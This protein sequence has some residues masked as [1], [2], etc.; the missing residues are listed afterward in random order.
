MRLITW[1]K[2][3][4]FD[5]F[6]D[7]SD[8]EKGDALIGYK[9][10]I[11]QTVPRTV[12]TKLDE[13]VSVKD[14]GAKGN[15]YTD[16]SLAIQTAIDHTFQNGTGGSIFF[17]PGN[18][19]VKTGIHIKGLRITL[20]G[21]GRY[22]T[23]VTFKPESDNLTLFK[24][25]RGADGLSWQC[26]IQD[27]ALVSSGST[28]FTKTALELKDTSNMI[29]KDLIIGPWTGNGNSIGLLIRGRE[30][31]HINN[32]RIQADRPIFIGKNGSNPNNDLDHFHF[33][34]LYLLVSRG[35]SQPC[36]FIDNGVDM[37]HVIFD[38]FQAWVLGTHGLY[39]HDTL[40][41]R[42]ALALTFRNIRTEQSTYPNGYSIYIHRNQPIQDLIIENMVADNSQRGFF[43][44][45]INRLTMRHVVHNGSSVALDIDEV[46][47]LSLEQVL[48]GRNSN[49][50]MPNMQEKFALNRLESG[51]P[52][53]DTAYFI[54][55]VGLASSQALHFFGGTKVWSFSGTLPHN[56]LLTIPAGNNQGRKAGVIWVSAITEDETINAGGQVMDTINGAIRLA[57][58][59]NFDVGNI[60]GKLTVFHTGATQIFNKLGQSVDLMVFATWT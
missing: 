45:K 53:P 52:V 11:A 56:E 16:D 51:R 22:A 5:I 3:Y 59:D 58:T 25:D 1:L 31:G 54:Q 28:A 33:S 17:P 55:N 14:F 34:D 40:T 57:G 26:A 20:Y 9:Q 38:G 46:A 13:V 18:Y 19:V 49:V 36:I 35:V 42:V 44:R 37:Q 48:M 6:A 24:F 21:A 60:D 27:M 39:W 23:M 32:V 8:E 29:V 12:H 15:G 43:F 10:S 41:T 50:N 2:K 4:I 7:T 30:A 47:E